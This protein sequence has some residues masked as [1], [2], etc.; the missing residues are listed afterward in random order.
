[1]LKEIVCGLHPDCAKP[2]HMFDLDDDD[3]K[4]EEGEVFVEVGLT[5][6]NAA[7]WFS[8]PYI[9]SDTLKTLGI[10]KS[11]FGDCHPITGN[12]HDFYRM[13]QVDAKSVVRRAIMLFAKSIDDEEFLNFI[14][15]E[16]EKDIKQPI[17]VIATPGG[18]DSGETSSEDGDT[19]SSSSE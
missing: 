19:S 11:K 9:G 17:P 12:K 4:K 14:G 15:I 13:N 10:H 6:E 16:R 1:M 2:F 8:R 5:K 18:G 3:D 7:M